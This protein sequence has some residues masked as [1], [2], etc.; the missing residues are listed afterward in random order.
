VQERS[1]AERGWRLAALLLLG[2]VAFFWMPLGV[3]DAGGVSS[4]IP[5]L[6]PVAQSRPDR[7][8]RPAAVRPHTGHRAVPAVARTLVA[9]AA[10]PALLAAFALIGLLAVSLLPAPRPPSRGRIRARGPPAVL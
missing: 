4:V 8:D 10:L 3:R 6:R 7:P 1:R 5:A 9:V 2:L